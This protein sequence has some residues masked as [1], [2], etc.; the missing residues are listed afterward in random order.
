[1][2]LFFHSKS[3]ISSFSSCFRSWNGQYSAFRSHNY[4]KIDFTSFTILII[5]MSALEGETFRR[6]KLGQSGEDLRFIGDDRDTGDRR[7]GDWWLSRTV[8]FWFKSKKLIREIFL[9][10][11][12]EK[13]SEHFGI[14]QKIHRKM[15]EKCFWDEKC[16]K[17]SPAA[18]K[19][20]L[21]RRYFGSKPVQ[22][23]KNRTRRGGRKFWGWFL[24][25]PWKTKKHW[26]RSP[27]RCENI[28]TNRKRCM[29]TPNSPE[30]GKLHDDQF[31]F[32]KLERQSVWVRGSEQTFNKNRQIWNKIHA[33]MN[34]SGFSLFYSCLGRWNGV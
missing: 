5:Q 33:L 27:F 6:F 8:F 7:F 20:G 15:K 10:Y 25:D 2:L 26:S 11:S 18:R 19:N 16:S 13:K 4:Y 21:F 3:G 14:F 9:K 24:F 22:F 23:R 30:T 31:L 12:R 28:Q 29:T 32:R 17:C 1:M 34:K